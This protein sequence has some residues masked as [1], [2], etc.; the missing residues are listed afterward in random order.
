MIFQ[1]DSTKMNVDD[2]LSKSNGD[3]FRIISIDGCH[4]KRATYTDLKNA[5]KLLTDYGVIVCD[6]YENPY[7]PGVK[8]GVDQFLSETD[9]FVVFYVGW[10]KFILCQRKH[11]ELFKDK[12]HNVLDNKADEMLS[13]YVI[14]GVWLG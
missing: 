3:K 12:F 5:S 1:K 7:W 8:A 11:Y 2:Y 6:D 9:E 13:R 14:G 10:N 4:T